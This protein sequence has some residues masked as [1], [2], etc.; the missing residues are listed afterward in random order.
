MRK[1]IVLKVSFIILLFLT[2]FG[3]VEKSDAVGNVDRKRPPQDCDETD[4]NYGSRF[5]I[6]LCKL[7][8]LQCPKAYCANQ[9]CWC[10]FSSASS[11]FVRPDLVMPCVLPQF[12]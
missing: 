11:T 4:P 1:A 12:V 5:C 10:G 2:S 8:G 3:L 6:S 9:V 7:Q